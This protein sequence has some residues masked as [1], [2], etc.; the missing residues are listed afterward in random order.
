[1]KDIRIVPATIV[2]ALLYMGLSWVPVIGPLIVGFFAGW[3]RRGT[4][5]E[6]FNS[7]IFSGTLG[8]IGLTI[9]LSEI[10]IFSISGF[11]II[12]TV[13]VYFLYIA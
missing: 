3:V 1:M 7:G 10:E 8:F 12:I 4:A 9:L 5:K 13:F 6:G 11:R 2:G